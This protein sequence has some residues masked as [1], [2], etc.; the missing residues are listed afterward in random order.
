MKP[1]YFSLSP[2]NENIIFSVDSFSWKLKDE[3]S[4]PFHP[5]ASFLCNITESD[6]GIGG[7]RDSADG[8]NVR[9]CYFITQISFCRKFFISRAF[10]HLSVFSLGLKHNIRRAI[11]IQHV[12]QTIVSMTSH[13]VG[14]FINCWFQ[15]KVWRAKISVTSESWLYMRFLPHVLSDDAWKSMFVKIL[16]NDG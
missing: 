4:N 5:F 12:C 1:F 8:K 13:E 11:R 6:E 2:G 15:V 3:F 10:N 9:V 16:L 14:M 7:R